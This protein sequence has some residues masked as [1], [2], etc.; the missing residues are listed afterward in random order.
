[1]CACASVSTQVAQLALP[2]LVTRCE[3]VL[4]EFARAKRAAAAP[5]PAGAA[6]A[7]GTDTTAGGATSAAAPLAEPVG[8]RTSAELPPRGGAVHVP[9]PLS[10]PAVADPGPLADKA[11]LALELAGALRVVPAV[12]DALLP[13]RPHLRFWLEAA[14]A[15]TG[16]AA[17]PAPAAAAGAGAAGG[18]SALARRSSSGAPA[19]AGEPHGLA[20]GDAGAPLAGR[21]S[22][23]P[24]SSFFS[25]SYSSHAA[26][27]PGASSSGGRNGSGQP[28]PRRMGEHGDGPGPSSATGGLLAAPAAART[29]PPLAPSAALHGKA[30]WTREQ[31]QLIALFGVL[32]ECVGASEPG[33]HGAAA[34]LL[35]TAGASL[36]LCAL[37]AAHALPTTSESGAP[38]SGDA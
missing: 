32:V 20:G 30:A 8:E 22:I 14:R 21:P 26:L 37:P 13:S 15:A 23:S 29:A 12:A 9:A 28:S 38:P 35:A 25:R 5:P 4:A 33:V 6:P 1:M 2:V 34:A 27:L 17:W 24:S 3:A 18:P 19:L 16:A 10:Q 31:P 36:G 7:T 11:A